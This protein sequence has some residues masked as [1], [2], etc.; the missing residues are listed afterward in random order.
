MNLPNVIDSDDFNG[1]YELLKAGTLVEPSA[2]YPGGL[3]DRDYSEKAKAGR[4][5]AR[6]ADQAA[7]LAAHREG[8]ICFVC[9]GETSTPN[10]FK[11]CDVC[12]YVA[13]AG[14]VIYSTS[15]P[16]SLC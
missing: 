16:E 4:L 14:C 6:Y 10:L 3:Q 5:Q 13:C 1:V 12:D 15:P 9:K 8:M 7:R 11:E 2:S